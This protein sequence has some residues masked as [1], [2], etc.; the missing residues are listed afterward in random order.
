MPDDTHMDLRER[1]AAL[2]QMLV[3]RTAERDERLQQE[4]ATPFTRPPPSM[5]RSNAHEHR[6]QRTGCSRGRGC[7]RGSAAVGL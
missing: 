7:S 4:S 6:F 5:G 1:V 2:K 3:E